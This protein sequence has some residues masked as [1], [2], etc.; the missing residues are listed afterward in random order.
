MKK[1]IKI[2]GSGFS[3]L[4][5]S[6]YLAQKGYDVDVYEKNST[7]GGRAR[8][9]KRDGFTFDIGP[10]W[11]WMPDV[12]ERFFGDFNKK[13][14]DY[15]D[16]IK[17][18]PAYQVYFGIN[19][20]VTIADNLPEIVA[21]FESIEKGSGEKLT[22]FIKEAQSN[23]DIAIKDLVYRPGVSPLELVTL[24]TAKKVDQF[25]GNISKDIRRRFKNKKL[26]QILEFPVLFL[27]AKP[28]DTPTFYNFMNF[29]DFGLG[30]WH[31]KNGMYSVILAMEKL[32]KELGVTIN[33]DSNVEKIIVENGKATAI[34][35]NGETLSADVILSG[36]DYHHSE[37][38]LDEKYRA[39][40][41]KYWESRVFAPSSLLFYVG[42]DKKIENVEHHS[43][44]FDVDF[45]VHAKD[46][47]DNPKWPEEPLFY[48]SFPSKTDENSAPVGKEAA[49]FLIPLAPGL[50]DTDALREK[51]FEKIMIRLEQLT[52]Q[53]LKNNIIF[54]QS[55]CVNDFINDY[56]SYKGNAYGMANT[57]LQ[58][59][60]LRP[61]LKSKKVKSLYFTG[62]LTVPGPGVP[63]ALI[64]GKLVADLIQKHS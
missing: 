52:Q 31:P 54:K 59:A 45:D 43:L 29:A 37:T 62:Q 7:I 64:S 25:F 32:A 39:Y 53:S 50:N 30:T 4:A 60:F 10:T 46:I 21:T 8:Q 1:K 13:P 12:F 48:A 57:L 5:A 47:Y 22:T 55:F 26:V 33:T 34:V 15:Y 9:L 28:S 49:I 41:E 36:A 42:F 56:N 6:C 51:Y 11:Y 63:P 19:E 38:L 40:S 44:F 18:S 20:F 27:G 61:K 58:T 2:I 35:I 3:A 14:S 23:Y 17:L 16:L 24:E